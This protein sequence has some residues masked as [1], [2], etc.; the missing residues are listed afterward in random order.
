MEDRGNGEGGWG[1]E[2]LEWGFASAHQGDTPGM[3]IGLHYVCVDCIKSLQ[4]SWQQ[5]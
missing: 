4:L 5:S 3:P 2:V 1:R